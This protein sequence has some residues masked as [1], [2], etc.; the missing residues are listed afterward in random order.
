MGNAAGQRCRTFLPGRKCPRPSTQQRPRSGVHPGQGTR[1]CGAETAGRQR[2]Q[3]LLL[4]QGRR[5]L[6]RVEILHPTPQNA[7]NHGGLRAVEVG[8]RSEGMLLEELPPALVQPTTKVASV[9]HRS[10]G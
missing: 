9:A 10:E 5:S 8:Q 3:L 6:T 7:G 1:G 4:L 2:V